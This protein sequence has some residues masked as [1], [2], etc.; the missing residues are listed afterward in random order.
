MIR[1]FRNLLLFL[2]NKS[3]KLIFF[4]ILILLCNCSF[5]NKTGIWGGDKKEKR[6]I[7]ELE[8]EQ[9][10][11]INITKIYS[12]ES[13]YSKELSLNKN[14]ALLKPK[15]NQSWQMSGLNYQNFLRVVD[16]L[17]L[18]LLILQQVV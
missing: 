14:I 17:S 8:L 9:K 1:Q 11:V 16:Y 6:R 4:L 7:Y 15:T 18:L 3:K 12:S 5:D 2:M 10:E 13:I